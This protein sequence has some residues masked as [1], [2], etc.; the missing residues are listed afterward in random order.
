ML[1]CVLRSRTHTVG[2]NIADTDNNPS[3]S[4]PDDGRK[5]TQNFIFT[6][7]CSVSKGLH[8]TFRGTTNKCEKKFKLIFILTE[9]SEMH[10][11]RR[12]VYIVYDINILFMS[13]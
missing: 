6:F 11:P 2:K 13:K 4:I 3:R 7:L 9:L 10:G 1:T 5:L 8:K 12:G